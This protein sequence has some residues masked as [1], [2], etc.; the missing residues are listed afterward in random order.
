[1]YV[2]CVIVYVFV[3]CS[4]VDVLICYDGFRVFDVFVVIF[5]EVVVCCV[6]SGDYVYV[7]FGVIYV[8]LFDCVCVLNIIGCMI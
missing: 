3:L 5:C 4:F 7:I 2:V 8:I 1:M 6:F